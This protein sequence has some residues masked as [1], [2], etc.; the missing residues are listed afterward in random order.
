MHSIAPYEL[1]ISDADLPKERRYC[2]MNNIRGRR[3]SDILKKFIEEYSQEFTQIHDSNITKSF[4][5]SDCT[6]T[7]NEVYGFTETGH[8]GIKGRIIST[9]EN[10]EK[11]AYNKDDANT[12]RK[13]FYISYS[14]TNEYATVHLHQINTMGAKTSILQLL[15]A[16]IQREVSEKL[17]ISML[18]LTFKT[19]LKQWSEH[20][21]V[22][23]IRG[24][25]HREG[26]DDKF[27]DLRQ[28]HRIEVICKP[29]KRGG[30]FGFLRNLDTQQA[31]MLVA[32]EELEPAQTKVKVELNGKSKILSVASDR[33]P[34]CTIDFTEHDVNMPDGEPEIESIR[35]FCQNLIT[36]MGDQ[37]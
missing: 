3:L 16:Y 14:D 20:S 13:F 36:Q 8:S 5:F 22:K 12:S 28:S 7:K 15:I 33:T 35:E 24:I 17:S 37:G 21:I 6:T 31:S 32:Y 26:S 34:I 11:F 1:R 19:A 2:P 10:K 29:H 4:L 27:D 23:E 30:N 18:P 25:V 9:S